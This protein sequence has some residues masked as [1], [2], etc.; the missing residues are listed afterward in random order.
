[1]NQDTDMQKTHSTLSFP[2]NNNS[3]VKKIYQEK[4]YKIIHTKAKNKNAI[5]FFSG[6]GLY[7]PNE[8]KIFSETIIEKN[9]YEWENIS[10]NKKIKNKY[11]LII[12]VRDIYKQW[13]LNGINSELDTQEKVIEELKK[14]T[15]GYK[16]TTCGNSAG[17][18]MATLVGISINAENIFSFSGQ[19][20]LNS[21]KYKDSII[22]ENL[23]ALKNKYYSLTEN[24]KTAKSNIFFFYPGL[25]EQDINQHNIIKGF[26]IF[27]FSF[28]TETHGQSCESSCYCYLLT[29]EAD[30]L[31]KLFLKYKNQNIDKKEFSKTIYKKFSLWKYFKLNCKNILK[32]KRTKL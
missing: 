24:I 7:F 11:S 21:Q 30:Y 19:F 17:G 32:L 6:N 13:Y 4:N 20:D 15:K 31:K 5:I 3:M 18:Y 14:I 10:D 22:E 8:E 1:M 26:N 2:W 23:N 29:C 16:V 12:F 28:D 9:R 25:C 27:S